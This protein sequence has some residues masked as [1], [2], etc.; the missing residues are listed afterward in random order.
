MSKL[1]P[2][3]TCREFVDEVTNYLEGKLTE[4]EQQWTEEHLAHC[5][6]CR[7]YLDQMRATIEA[8]R[9]L[10]EESLGPELRARILDAI[11]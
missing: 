5:D 9:G 4:A 2:N 7:A 6:H 11:P 1:H 3:L 8:L 10:R